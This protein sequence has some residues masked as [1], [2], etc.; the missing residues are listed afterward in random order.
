MESERFSWVFRTD[1]RT[2]WQPSFLSCYFMLWF[3]LLYIINVIFQVY[4]LRRSGMYTNL[5]LINNVSASVNSFRA[6]LRKSF[7]MLKV[8]KFNQPIKYLLNWEWLNF[9]LEKLLY[10]KIGFVLIY[11][12]ATLH[13]NAEA[14]FTYFLNDAIFSNLNLATRGFDWQWK[15]IYIDLP[16]A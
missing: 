9:S 5:V 1:E 11:L 2:W 3:F 16:L 10:C 12:L 7:P 13:N 14:S 15:K 6:Y 4:D 8:N